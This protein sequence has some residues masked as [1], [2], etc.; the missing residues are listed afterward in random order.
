VAL[1]GWTEDDVYVMSGPAYHASHLGWSLCALFVGALPWSKSSSRP[2]P[3]WVRWPAPGTRTFMCGP[4]IR[5][6][7]LSRTSARVRCVEP[8]PVVHAAAPCPVAVKRRMME[9]FPSVEI[10]WLYGAARAVPPKISPRSAGQTRQCGPTLPGWRS[11]PDEEGGDVA[12]ANP[13]WCTSGR[14]VPSGPL[15]H[16][17]E[18]RTAWRDDAFHRR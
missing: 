6:L 4:F 16:D 2:A 15:P 18:A 14:P 8:A 1:W 7:E 12:T 11:D 9:A 17:D 3:G 5:I 10:H 13:V